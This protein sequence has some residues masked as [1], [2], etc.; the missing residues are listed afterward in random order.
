MD[1]LGKLLFSFTLDND[2]SWPELK[3]LGHAVRYVN[4]RKISA[5]LIMIIFVVILLTLMISILVIVLA[6]AFTLQA[7][8]YLEYS[9]RDIARNIRKKL[10]I[11]YD[12]YEDGLIETDASGSKTILFKEFKFMRMNKDT[13][14]MV[15]KGSDVV[16]VPRWLLDKHSDS[17]MM[18]LWRV[19]GNR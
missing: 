11:Q 18:K 17:L 13:F 15:G 10:P 1:D 6:L 16:V 9:S 14:T 2:M 5:Y 7:M 19:L 12:F 8:V 3:K 4:T